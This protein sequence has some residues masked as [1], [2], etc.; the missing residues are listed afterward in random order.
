MAAESE[1]KRRKDNIVDCT[2]D[3]E[4]RCVN[5]R[6]IVKYNS[7]RNVK[8][9]KNVIKGVSIRIGNKTI[10]TD[11]KYI[12]ESLCNIIWG[13]DVCRERG[14]GSKIDIRIKTGKNENDRMFEEFENIKRYE[15]EREE[16][17]CIGLF[18]PW[19]VD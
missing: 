17:C 19:N 10:E 9:S 11:M 4:L 18:C 13:S 6:V 15:I 16:E 1:V 2:I 8:N 12:L 5:V 14:L 3:A 7:N